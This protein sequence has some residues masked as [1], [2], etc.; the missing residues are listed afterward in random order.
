M[1]S[2]LQMLRRSVFSSVRSTV[3]L[4]STPVGVR[5]FGDSAPNTLEKTADG[6]FI[7]DNTA[8]T[9][10]WILSSPPPLHQF[11]EP[12]IIVEWPEGE[13]GSH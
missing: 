4:R 11:E 7:V 6:A 3:A 5:S 1:A 9:V 2:S 12:P 13:D 10:E 8:F